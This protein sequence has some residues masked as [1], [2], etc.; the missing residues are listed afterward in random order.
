MEGGSTDGGAT[1]SPLVRATF[2][3]GDETHAVHS[4]KGT[5]L[6]EQLVSFKEESMGV[7]KEFIINNNAPA[8]VPDEPL[9]GSDGDDDGETP[10]KPPVK[11][12]K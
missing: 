10:A 3:L 12:R 4:I 5:S 6:S 1:L 2:R 11:K 9:E 8:D 7:L